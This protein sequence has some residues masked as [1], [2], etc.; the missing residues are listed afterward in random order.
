MKATQGIKLV[1]QLKCSF[2]APGWMDLP[3]AGRESSM[4]GKVMDSTW[5]PSLGQTGNVMRSLPW[6]NRELM[7]SYLT[8]KYWKQSINIRNKDNGYSTKL[9]LFNLVPEISL[10]RA[11]EK[12]KKWGKAPFRGWLLM[13]NI[14]SSNVSSILHR[15]FSNAHPQHTQLDSF[16]STQ[17]NSVPEDSKT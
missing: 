4:P 3:L 5:T 9:L 11:I 17:Y 8:I 12:E 10:A 7:A 15:A 2:I 1:Q 14:S 13:N 16:N 6:L